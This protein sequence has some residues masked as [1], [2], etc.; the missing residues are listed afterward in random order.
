MSS[1]TLKPM[2]PLEIKLLHKWL[3]DPEVNHYWYG[4]DKTP[5]TL[6]E[7]KKDWKSCYFTNKH[8]EKGRCFLIQVKN[9]PIGMI[10][11]NKINKTTKS[12]EIDILIGD[13]N[14]WNKGYGTK[15]IKLFIPFV[16]KK[17]KLHRVWICS[18]ADNPRAIKTYLKA[19]F[20]KE[21]VL[22]DGDFYEGKFVDV[23][24]FSILE[25]D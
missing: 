17:L 7:L 25:N 11:Y 6:R 4:K 8:P 2:K 18:K 15:A 23:V 10:A 16:F 13:K 3:K 22:R 5:V 12:A 19:G 20:K 1:I 14:Y 21:G 24:L 9:K